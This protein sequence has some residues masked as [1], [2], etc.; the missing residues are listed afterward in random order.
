[1]DRRLAA[2]FAAGRAVMPAARELVQLIRAAN[3]PP[4]VGHQRE[5]G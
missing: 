4:R 2:A 5:L 1:M 3:L